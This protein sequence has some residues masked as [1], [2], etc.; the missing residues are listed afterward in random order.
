M[1]QKNMSI[2][3]VKLHNLNELIV[4]ILSAGGEYRIPL[5]GHCLDPKPQGPFVIKAGSSI[6]IPFKNI[7][8]HMKSFS[9]ST[10]S[11]AFVV[12]SSEV[13]KAKKTC[14][15]TVQFDPKHGQPQPGIYKPGKLTVTSSRS[16]KPGAGSWIF[17]LK[18][19]SSDKDLF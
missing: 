17:Y 3:N 13:L 19:V 14:G 4:T 15:I 1:Y 2:Y 6:T 8:N 5:K 7:F 10:D 16:G 11:Q 18:G 12:K 9:F